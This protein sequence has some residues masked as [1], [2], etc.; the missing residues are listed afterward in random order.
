MQFIT[1]SIVWLS[2]STHKLTD[3]Y[4]IAPGAT[5]TI[6]PGAIVDGQGYTVQ[7]GGTLKAVGSNAEHITLNDWNI[8]YLP[9]NTPAHIADIDISHAD[10]TNGSF[11][12]PTGDAVYG[13]F[14]LENSVIN[15]WTGY[16]Y[17]WYPQGAVSIQHDAFID[18]GGF[19]VGFDN[20]GSV[21][22]ED[23]AFLG[24]TDGPAIS[25]WADY[26]GAAL[27]ITQNDFL[28]KTEIALEAVSYGPAFNAPSN[29]FGTT[30]SSIINKMVTDGHDDLSLPLINL[31]KPLTAPS[32][33]APLVGSA[34]SDSHL[35][36]S[37]HDDI[38]IGFDGNDVLDGGSGQDSLYGGAGDDTLTGG[39]GDD[40]LS[41]GAGADKFIFSGHF[42]HD[43][44]IDF[45]A[46]GSEHDVVH[47]SASDF[48]NY[49]VLQEHMVQSGSDVLIQMDAADTILLHHVSLSALTAADFQFG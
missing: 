36:G 8:N 19:S 46:T 30:S 5:L 27:V 29:W 4:Q 10:I 15:G 18:S 45:T 1:H 25:V 40:W 49:A 41:G 47:F 9:G 32:T 33:D 26:N 43:T 37:S 42:G 17:V 39:A 7:V 16:S 35:T 14:T 24:Q 48:A 21:A 34:T 12:N 3:N 38:I 22:I 2:G 11:L 44:I 20:P 23:N 28:T 31:G 13:A 6:E